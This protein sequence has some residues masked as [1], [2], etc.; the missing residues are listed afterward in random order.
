MFSAVEFLKEDTMKNLGYL[1]IAIGFLV[2]SLA[3]ITNT[4]VVTG[5]ETVTDNVDWNF[6][7]PSVIVAMIGIVI[8]R[9]HD[10]RHSRS[11]E[12]LTGH[13]SDIE[14]SLAAIVKNI[15][16]MCD[17]SDAIDTYQVH[18]EI[19]EIFRADLMSFVDARTA[20]GHIYGMQEYADVMSYFASAER[21]INRAWSAS[22]D[23]YINEVK[24]SLQKAKD[25][26]C[27]VLEKINHLKQQST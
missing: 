16:A 21:A 24:I 19:D 26:F 17:N 5:T 1:L 25:Q 10:H 18:K 27:T 6:F 9:V 13:L 8:V 12:K 4:E 23:G 11:E 14:N 15:T 7:L 2:G 20:I 22:T 3:A